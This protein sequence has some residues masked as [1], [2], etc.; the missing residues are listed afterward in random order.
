MFIRNFILPINGII[1]YLSREIEC[2]NIEQ[3]Y[4]ESIRFKTD[5]NRDVYW[6]ESKIFYA[7]VNEEKEFPIPTNQ[8]QIIKLLEVS[9]YKLEYKENEVIVNTNLNDYG[10]E[11]LK[12]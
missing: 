7:L 4:K 6:I 1:P 2:E 9:G 12:L 10:L 3:G 5:A 11:R 8:I